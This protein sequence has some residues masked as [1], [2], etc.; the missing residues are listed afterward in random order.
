MALPQQKFR[1]V[2]FQ[3]LY[4]H[5]LSQHQG[6]E[7]GDLLMK[8]LSITRKAVREAAARVAKVWVALPQIDAHISRTSHA[9]AFD[10]IQAIE[11]NILRLGVYE[12]L[13]DEQ[14][15]PKVAIS[16]AMR[17]SK[18][19]GTPESVL[20]VN[21]ILD[22]IYKESRGEAVDQNHVRQATEAFVASEEVAKQASQEQKLSAEEE[23]HEE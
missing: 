6:E 21:A 10:R 14:I 4:S 7:V 16:E 3:M 1:E 2:V 11:R 22:A 17:L 20:F 15:P 12:L 13:M 8:E 23:E 18:K 19:F 9:Y 5:D